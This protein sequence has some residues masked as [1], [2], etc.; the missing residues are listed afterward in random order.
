M[1]AISASVSTAATSTFGDFAF[2]ASPGIPLDEG[3]KKCLETGFPKNVAVVHAPIKFEG[4]EGDQF[5]KFVVNNPQHDYVFHP[6]H[7]ILKRLHAWD[8]IDAPNVC[9]ENFPWSNKK[10]LR[11]PLDVLKFTSQ[12]GLGICF[13]FAHVDPDDE[14]EFKS[15]SFLRAYLPHVR[16]VHFSGNRHNALTE[17]EWMVWERLKKEAPDSLS[18]IKCFVLEHKSWDDKIKDGKRLSQ[19]LRGA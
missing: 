4:D 14:P 16:I 13:D 18:N 5:M 6:N 10:P 12:R 8:I 17:D 7:G 11:T 9:I 19:L 3:Y 2:Q 15:F 1:I